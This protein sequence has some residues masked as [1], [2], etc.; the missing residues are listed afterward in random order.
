[1]KVWLDGDRPQAVDE[2]VIDAG[3]TLNAELWIVSD[4][5]PDLDVSATLL[6][7]ILTGF[8]FGVVPGAV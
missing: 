7:V 4:S 2:R 1:M 6:A 5:F 3:L 8:G